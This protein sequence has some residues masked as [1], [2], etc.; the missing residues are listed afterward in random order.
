ML[1]VESPGMAQGKGQMGNVGL[2]NYTFSD[3]ETVETALVFPSSL[4][5]F[6][7]AA[8]FTSA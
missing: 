6:E 8:I 2:Q 3:A 7:V 5:S 4:I 1:A